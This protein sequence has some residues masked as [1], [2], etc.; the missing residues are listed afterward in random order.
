MAEN[1][2]NIEINS[3]WYWNLQNFIKFDWN[4]HKNDQK[5]TLI[6]KLNR[7]YVKISSKRSR[8]WRKNDWKMT[9]NI[10]KLNN[11]CLNRNL[12]LKMTE[13][14]HENDLKMTIYP[15]DNVTFNQKIF[16]FGHRN[17]INIKICISTK[18]GW[19]HWWK[20]NRFISIQIIKFII[21]QFDYILISFLIVIVFNNLLNKF[22][23]LN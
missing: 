10:K 4:G 5:I 23:W 17:D 22:I 2:T 7:F 9:K 20:F 12:K 14:G 16:E 19:N 15:K 11:S 6:F 8:N 13:N 1:D 3:L 21:N 18:Y